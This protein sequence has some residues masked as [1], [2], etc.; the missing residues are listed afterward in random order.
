MC[1]ARRRWCSHGKPLWSPIVP[2]CE[3]HV[4]FAHE[5]PHFGQSVVLPLNGGR[6]S[7]ALGG[8]TPGT[9]REPS[10]GFC[11]MIFL[12]WDWSPAGQVTEQV[13]CPAGALD[14][15]RSSHPC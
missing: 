2:P 5:S 14:G 6:F 7:L 8:R 10:S 12:A 9:A 1:S 4:T 3:C 15:L 11:D 13:A